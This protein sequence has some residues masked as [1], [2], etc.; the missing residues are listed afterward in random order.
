MWFISFPTWLMG[1][2]IFAIAYTQAIAFFREGDRTHTSTSDRLME[3]LSKLHLSRSIR[4]NKRFVVMG[5]TK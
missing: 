3:D 5:A 2:G 1:R 4:Q